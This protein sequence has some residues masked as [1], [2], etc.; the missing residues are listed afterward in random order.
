MASRGPRS[1]AQVSLAPY[2][3]ALAVDKVPPRHTILLPDILLM[4]FDPVKLG[5]GKF[6]EGIHAHVRR[7][8]DTHATHRGMDAETN[9]L[10]LLVV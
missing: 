5:N 7:G 9:V 8:R 2:I 4:F 3:V 10:D 1:P 6:A